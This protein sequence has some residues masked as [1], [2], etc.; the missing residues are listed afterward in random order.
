MIGER[1][2][3]LQ[4]TAS[5]PA[6][7]IFPVVS[8]AGPIKNPQGVVTV[9]RG[10][11]AEGAGKVTI[12]TVDNPVPCLHPVLDG[13]VISGHITHVTTTS[14]VTGLTGYA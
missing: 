4:D 14:G 8:G 10:L 9:L 2:T 6:R 12:I 13:E 7:Q 5:S 3:W 11:R 1:F